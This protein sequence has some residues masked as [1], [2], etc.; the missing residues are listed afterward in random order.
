MNRSD[1]TQ[2][3]QNNIQAGR[4]VNV[5]NY[6]DNISFD[7]QETEQL[8]MDIYEIS[9][10]M[11]V[12]Q[13]EFTYARM[14]K[15]ED[16]NKLNNMEEYFQSKIEK[17]IVYFDEIKQVLQLNEDD[18]RDRFEYIIGTIK[19]AILAIDDSE[20]LTPSKINLIFS[21][22]YKTDWDW[23]K[24]QKAERLIHFMYFYCFLGKKL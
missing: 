15:I 18:F 12:A 2:E 4:D 10:K 9:Q 1:Q 16:K 19:G 21:K 7:L 13:V 5:Y 17:D 24:K 14:E 3:G 23:Q 22:F 8:I 6:N 11:E 20:K